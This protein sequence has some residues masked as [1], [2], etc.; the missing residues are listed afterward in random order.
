MDRRTDAHSF[1]AQGKSREAFVAEVESFAMDMMGVA[2]TMELIA[3][4]HARQMEGVAAEM[5]KQMRERA[6][7]LLRASLV[8]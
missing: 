1:A 8:D 5:A 6:A 7:H 2:D 4:N 3:K